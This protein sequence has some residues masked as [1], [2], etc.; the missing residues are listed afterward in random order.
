[1][2][3]REMIAKALSDALA[4]QLGI[5]ITVQQALRVLESAK[6]LY[7]LALLLREPVDVNAEELTIDVRDR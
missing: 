3:D 4:G 2:T 5:S 6:D 1:M 7:D